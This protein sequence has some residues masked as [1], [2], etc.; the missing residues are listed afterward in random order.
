MPEVM[1]MTI[2]P[3]VINTKGGDTYFE[4]KTHLKMGHYIG[5]PAIEKVVVVVYIIIILS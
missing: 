4:K 3:E 1:E 5:F 2:D